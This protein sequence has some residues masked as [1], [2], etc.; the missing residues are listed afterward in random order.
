MKKIWIVAALAA[1]AIA[2]AGCKVVSE[3]EPIAVQS[4]T[5]D[6]TTL[7][8]EP[9]KTGKLTATVNPD[10]AD[11]KSVKWSSSDKSVAMV[12]SAGNVVAIKA[13]TAAITAQAGD[14][15]AI[16]VI[17][18]NETAVVNPDFPVAVESVTLNAT[19][20]TI[21]PGKTSTLIATVTPSNANDKTVV[22]SSSD[23]AV[24]T[25]D[26]SGTVTAIATGR[27]GD[28][29]HAGERQNGDMRDYRKDDSQPSGE[30]LAQ[31]DDAHAHARRDGKIDSNGNA[32]KRGRQDG[33]MVV[34]SC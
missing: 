13:G 18:V 32:G 22:W 3:P 23:T 9:G 30:R 11:D 20:L 12:D 7:T 21:E 1:F 28:Y 26:N 25:V 4:V 27:H 29:H 33:N 31:R 10:N 34:I 19:T 14:K 15:T 16:C 24:A 5:L 8:I 17:T 2:L 6:A